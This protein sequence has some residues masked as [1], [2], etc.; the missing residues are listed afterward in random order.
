MQQVELRRAL[1]S[2][3]FEVHY[4]PQV[5]LID[6]ETTGFEALVRWRHPERGIV[7]PLAFI[8]LAEE[9][10][11]IELLGD[12]VLRTACRDAQAWPVPANGRPLRVAVN[13]SPLQFRDPRALLSGI[14]LALAESELPVERLELELTENALAY[15]VADTLVAIRRMEIDLALDDFGTGYSSL[16]RLRG[17]AFNRL[18]IDRSF[19]MDLG[20]EGDANEQRAAEWMIRAIASLGL[21]LGLTTIVEGVETPW[22]LDIARRAGCTEM[23]GYLASRPVA[24]DAVPDLIRCLDDP[25]HPWKISPDGK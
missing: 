6:G 21:G 5:S 2:E 12:W 18:K 19:V 24:R 15:D 1:V 11:L 25:Q 13:L 10:G 22:Q 23:Q 7:P 17:H 9:I 4:Q 3:Q 8:P 16:G 14:R 20:E